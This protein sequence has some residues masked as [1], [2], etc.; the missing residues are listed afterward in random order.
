[1]RIRSR[2]IEQRLLMIALNHRSRLVRNNILANT[3]VDD[4]DVDVAREI[5]RRIDTLAKLGKKPGDIEAFAEDPSLSKG[6]RIFILMNPRARDKARMITKERVESMLQTLQ[7]YRRSRTLLQGLRRVTRGAADAIS[8]ATLQTAENEL[9]KTLRAIRSRPQQGKSVQY[10]VGMTKRNIHDMVKRMT[11]P[12]DDDFIPTG[13]AG[14]DIQITGFQRGDLVVLS[15]Q[16]GGLK[17]AT[18]LQMAWNQYRLGYNVAFCTMEMAWG[19][20]E[21]RLVSQITGVQYRSIRDKLRNA[22]RHEVK[23]I[24]RQMYRPMVDEM[25]KIGREKNCVFVPL[26]RYDATYTPAKLEMDLQ[27][28]KYDAVFIDY[29]TMFHFAAKDLWAGQMEYSRYLK[30]MA[31]RLGCVVVLLTQLNDDDRVKYGKGP[32]EAADWW[33]WWR[34]GEEERKT[35]HGEIRLAKAR[36]GETCMLPVE[37]MPATMRISVGAPQQGSSV[38]VQTAKKVS[39]WNAG[40]I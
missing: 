38:E 26:D 39:S 3:E 23:N 9:E 5:R 37:F 8:E 31:E 7:L 10:G 33:L 34:Y 30:T 19:R 40:S 24:R 15:A 28:F 14:L 22:T 21:E 29:L 16:R 27:G 25:V 17:T 32:E 1:M 11:T 20:L 12:S 35:K 6:A 13:L 4:F 2:S 36:A 18:A